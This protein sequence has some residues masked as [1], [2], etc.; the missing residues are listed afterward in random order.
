[1]QV[2]H[3]PTPSTARASRQ[4]CYLPV[5]ADFPCG[6]RSLDCRQEGNR[7]VLGRLVLIY[8]FRRVTKE[9]NLRESARDDKMPGRHPLKPPIFSRSS[10]FQ[11]PREIRSQILLRSGLDSTP[12]NRARDWLVGLIKRVHEALDPVLVDLTH[13]HFNR[14]LRRLTGRV[15]SE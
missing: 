8:A 7:F 9:R 15:G 11:I 10:H 2:D 3:A 1:V 13:K 12:E 5:P 14:L 6:S 4:L